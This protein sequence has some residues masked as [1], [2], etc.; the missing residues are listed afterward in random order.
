MGSEDKLHAVGATMNG[1]RGKVLET[2]MREGG[3]IE[4]YTLANSV[5][6]PQRCAEMLDLTLYT[7]CR[8]EELLDLYLNT[9]LVSVT[10]D[11]D[12][13]ITTAVAEDQISQNRYV[14]TAKVFVDATGDGRLGAE[15]GASFIMGRESKAEYNE[16][17]A[18]AK[19]D[20]ETE[21]SSL[22]FTARDYGHPMPFTPPAW[23]TKYHKDDFKY[24]G[25]GAF[26]CAWSFPTLLRCLAL[27]R[28]KKMLT[29]VAADGYWW[30]EISWPFNTIRD[31]KQ[32]TD[33]LMAD[34]LGVC[35]L[36]RRKA[37]FFGYLHGRVCRGLHQEQRRD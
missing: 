3:I 15:A 21:G 6:N 11:K 35:E 20:N 32:I 1:G 12:S 31:N 27:L 7:M 23:A 16:S 34:L 30:I 9:W 28:A 10:K 19:A 2:E 5:A 26:D 18:Q 13:G 33:L 17:L 8:E 25:V 22:A 36:Y 29:R 4:E 24:R 37:L 14:I